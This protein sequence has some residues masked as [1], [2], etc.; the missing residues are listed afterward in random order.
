MHSEN[1]NIISYNLNGVRSAI[2]KGLATWIHETNYDVYLFQEIKAD[3]LS[4]PVEYFDNIGYKHIW[5]PAQKKGYSG[6]GVLYKAHLEIENIEYGMGISKYDAEGRYIQFDIQ[7]ITIINTYFPSGSSGEERQQVK[8]DFLADYLQ[9]INTLKNQKQKIIIAGDYNICHTE[10]DIHDP[11]GNKN[12]SGFLPEE[13]QW[14]T[15]FFNNGFLDSFRI[16]NPDN[17]HQYSWWSFRAG[18]RSKN[19]GW[20]IDY[21]NCSQ[22]LKDAIIEAKILMDVV[23]SDHCPVFLKIKI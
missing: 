16:L 18:A 2:S 9:H 4:I 15:D 14:M 21:I 1:L 5:F 8:M 10:I 17:L 13:R 3:L 20:R 22:N 6:V 11:K 7:G 23:H 12:S 19:K